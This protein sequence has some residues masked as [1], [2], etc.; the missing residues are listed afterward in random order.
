[1]SIR[2]M[3]T[4]SLKSL[5]NVP[6]KF[7]KCLPGDIYTTNVTDENQPNIM[8]T[9]RPVH[10]AVYSHVY[11]EKA[12]DPIVLAISKPACQAIDL[13]ITDEDFA[14]VFSGNKVLPDTR[15]WSLCYA[16]HQFG[17]YAGQL[18]DGRA[19]SLFETV[20]SK[21]QSWEIQL[22]GAGRTPY[23][24]FG[25]GYA[26][27]RSSIREF[28]MSE[29][30]HALGVPTTRA[31]ALV[32]TSRDVYREDGP[33]EI[34]PETG[35]IVARMAP[36]W[37]R[38][39]NFE[40]FYH[41]DDM[42]NVRKLA[43][44]TIENVVTEQEG[45]GNKYAQMF[46]N[47]TKNTAKMVAEWQAIGFNHGVMNTD[48][49]S[50]LGLTMDYGPF[51]VMDFYNPRY[52]CNHSD[53][54]GRYAFHRQ[55]SVCIFNLV[56][57]SIPLFE[58]IGAGDQV[59]SLVFA[60]K[61]DETREG[62]TSEQVLEEYRSKAQHFVQ[63]LLQE[64]FKEYFMSSLLTKMRSKLG[65]K[66]C[67]ENK[68]DMD[69]V[70]IP[71]LDWMTNH[72]IDYHKFYRSLSNYKMTSEGEES[73]HEKAVHEWLDIYAEQESQ[74]EESKQTLK[75][76]LA[77]Y[78]HRLIKEKSDCEERKKRMDAVNPRFVLRN[79]IA[80]KV[81]ESFEK[82]TEDEAK[83]VLNACLDACIN[84]FQDHY[85]DPRVEEWI[86]SPI[87]DKDMRCSCSS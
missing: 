72:H 8:R 85:Q 64:E 43:D 36:S 51:Q 40:I 63:K 65:L 13:D 55:P 39:G 33:R 34:Q 21:G 26:V 56:R 49:M 53:E 70:I 37:L 62:V 32:E 31:L 22:K 6:T 15:P 59:D 46:R 58:L 74:V 28:L 41:R 86:H 42:D 4:R 18:G 3:T 24:R 25:D 81:I 77:I 14:D 5:P 83:Q 60:S 11:P 35:A 20:N 68:S 50:V 38:F 9:P 44:Y 1:M 61:E 75:A 79:S 73:D 30:M 57:L 2:N 66:E 54:T 17:Y 48:N 10:G 12:P 78:R 82:D 80:E 84:P 67:S 87:P 7:T 52:V 76:W 29:H 71:L 16:G 19:I 23:S 69:D 27:L 47:I 45:S